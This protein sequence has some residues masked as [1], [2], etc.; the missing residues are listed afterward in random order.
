M[1]TRASARLSTKCAGS[2]SP[3]A[4]TILVVIDAPAGLGKMLRAVLRV[5]RELERH[6]GIRDAEQPESQVVERQLEPQPLLQLPATAGL[7]GAPLSEMPVGRHVERERADAQGPRQMQ[8]A[9]VARS[10]ANRD[11]P[12]S[13]A[14]RAPRPLGHRAARPARA[15]APQR[16]DPTAR[17]GAGRRGPMRR[18]AAGQQR[19]HT[20]AVGA[21][22]RMSRTAGSVQAP[23]RL[24]LSRRL[25]E[26]MRPPRSKPHRPRRAARDATAPRRNAPRY[27]RRGRPHRPRLNRAGPDRRDLAGTAPSP[28]CREWPRCGRRRIGALDEHAA[29]AELAVVVGQRVAI[30]VQCRGIIRPVLQA[31]IEFLQGGADVSRLLVRR[32]NGVAQIHTVR[33]L[34]PCPRSSTASGLSRISGIGSRSWPVPRSPPGALRAHPR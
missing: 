4:G 5:A 14:G 1:R 31:L 24:Q 21:H 28:G 33:I 15:R 13:L 34:L 17:G 26:S 7:G 19:A 25:S 27:R 9:R 10:A 11:W 32:G 6:V 23:A 8:L 2:T 16:A 12:A 18:G 29:C 30:G 20:R 22:A 3:P